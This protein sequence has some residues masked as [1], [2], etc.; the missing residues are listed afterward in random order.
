[1]LQPQFTL[2]L[3]APFA[4]WIFEK[5]NCN[6]WRKDHEFT[7]VELRGGYLK[8]EERTWRRGED[9]GAACHAVSTWCIIW[10]GRT[11]SPSFFCHVN[12]CIA[13]SGTEDLQEKDLEAGRGTAFAWV[14]HSLLIPALHISMDAFH[15][16]LTFFYIVPPLSAWEARFV[17]SFGSKLMWLLVIFFR[18]YGHQGIPGWVRCCLRSEKLRNTSAGV[19][20]RV[21]GCWDRR[22]DMKQLPCDTAVVLLPLLWRDDIFFG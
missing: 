19:L 22:K 6:Q 5:A 9:N 20:R 13:L 7:W 17:G 15:S 11:V 16:V 10:I 3:L 8:V 21:R 4:A 18:S 14:P 2:E 12:F 1:M